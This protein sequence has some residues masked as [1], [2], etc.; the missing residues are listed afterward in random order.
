MNC[1]LH[2]NWFDLLYNGENNEIISSTS[3]F[4]PARS[5][6]VRRLEIFGAVLQKS[7][8]YIQSI[9]V[10]VRDFV[11]YTVFENS[12]RHLVEFISDIIVQSQAVP[13]LLATDDEMVPSH[14]GSANLV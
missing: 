11:V 14:F 1:V 13:E 3:I 5:F 2:R 8:K 10:F 4:P 9:L 12:P 7:G 6:W